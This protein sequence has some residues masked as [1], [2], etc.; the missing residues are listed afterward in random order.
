MHTA[1]TT[2]CK[3]LADRIREKVFNTLLESNVTLPDESDLSSGEEDLALVD[4]GK[5]SKRTRRELMQ[6]INTKYVFPNFN[7]LLYAEN[8]IFPVASAV[9]SNEPDRE[10]KVIEDNRD[11]IYDLYYKALKLEPEAKPEL[12]FTERQLVARARQ[13]ITIR[14]RKRL[15]LRRV[16][17]QKKT[18][19]K[20]QKMIA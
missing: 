14:M 19:M 16:K 13:F 8:Y 10:V 12:S 6:L 2:K 1:A 5:M 3:I 4:G 17:Q 18:N 9:A 20:L 7:I 15:E 11:S